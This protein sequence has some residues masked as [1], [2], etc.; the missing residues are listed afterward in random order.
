MKKYSAKKKRRTCKKG[1]AQT[2]KLYF[3]IM[4]P[5][6]ISDES[7]STGGYKYAIIN[8]EE[9]LVKFC[10]NIDELKSTYPHVNQ[11]IK[12]L[13]KYKIVD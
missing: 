5:N 6:K 4:D 12:K 10:G 9:D 13:I 11:H 8:K 3:S 2:K 1:G 7:D